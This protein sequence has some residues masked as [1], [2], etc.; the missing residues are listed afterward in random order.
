M[1]CKHEEGPCKHLL[2]SEPGKYSCA[3][4][5]H[6]IYKHTPCFQHTQIEAKNSNCRL[7]ERILKMAS[8]NREFN[9]TRCKNV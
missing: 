2:G 1:V 9:L 5:N 6:L 4:H 8:K 3:I 7:G